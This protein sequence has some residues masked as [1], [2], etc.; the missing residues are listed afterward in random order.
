MDS[1]RHEV[2]SEG[3]CDEMALR[4]LES[5]TSREEVLKWIDEETGYRITLRNYP[6]DEKWLLDLRA[7]L[8]AKLGELCR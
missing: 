3:F 2:I 6:H 8:N 1:L 5:K 4:L 7:K